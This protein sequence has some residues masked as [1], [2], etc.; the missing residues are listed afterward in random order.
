MG[1]VGSKRIEFR[2]KFGNCVVNLVI[3]A[4]HIVFLD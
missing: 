1:N 2:G 4:C 3:Y